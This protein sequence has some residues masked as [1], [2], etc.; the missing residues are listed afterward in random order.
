MN[1][2]VGSL[3][4][5]IVLQRQ[6][7]NA[8]STRFNGSVVVDHTANATCTTQ[9]TIA[10]DVGNRIVGI[11]LGTQ[12]TTQFLALC[13]CTVVHD[14]YPTLQDTQGTTQVI[15]VTCNRQCSRSFLDDT[16]HRTIIIVGGS[17]GTCQCGIG[18]RIT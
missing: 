15:I 5:S 10:E 11:G 9:H 17:N 6:H 14:E 4:G 2:E 16:Q 18:I 1:G 12:R 8:V 3:A 7:T 13:L